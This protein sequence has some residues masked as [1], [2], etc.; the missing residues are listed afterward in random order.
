SKRFDLKF[1]G[2]KDM[3]PFSCLFVQ[4]P[5]IT[6][7]WFDIFFILLF[8]YLLFCQIQAIWSF[9]IDDMYISLRYAKNW[10]SGHGLLWNI[11]SPPV[12]GYSNFSFVVI[13]ALAL[14][15]GINSVIALKF[16]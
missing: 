2:Q 3:R 9:T 15:M 11:D 7:R 16:L 1:L 8:L 5:K 4:R 13:A 12:E 14:H 10:A 6:L